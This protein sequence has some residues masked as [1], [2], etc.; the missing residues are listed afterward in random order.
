MHQPNRKDYQS[1][2]K[3]QPKARTGEMRKNVT[4]VKNRSHNGYYYLKGF[5]L[6]HPLHGVF[7]KNDKDKYKKNLDKRSSKSYLSESTK[8]VD[9]DLSLDDILQKLK[10]LV[11]SRKEEAKVNVTS[12]QLR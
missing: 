7:P 4:I 3:D 1:K 8:N 11:L 5:P 2:D 12:E 6:N 9:K 10:E